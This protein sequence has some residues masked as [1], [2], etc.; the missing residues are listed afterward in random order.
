M[1]IGVPDLLR[2]GQWLHL[3]GELVETRYQVVCERRTGWHHTVLE[4]IGRIR[5]DSTNA[6]GHQFWGELFPDL[7]LESLEGQIDEFRVWNPWTHPG[8]DPRKLVLRLFGAMSQVFV[9]LWSFEDGTPATHR[10]ARITEKFVGQAT[11]RDGR[12]SH[13][14][15]FGRV[16]D[17]AGK[18]QAGATIE[19]AEARW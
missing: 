10:L 15:V 13:G 8:S 4:W 9:G 3:A 16:T 5:D 18:P 7:V 2:P 12:A 11:T 19:I 6:L 14:G 17:V 1:R